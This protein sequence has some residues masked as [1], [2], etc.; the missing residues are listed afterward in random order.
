MYAPNDLQQDR[1]QIVFATQV[2]SGAWKFYKI[3]F[4]VKDEK[5]VEVQLF[6]ID[7]E[8]KLLQYTIDN[9]G[10]GTPNELSF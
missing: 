7:E 3:F 6:L 2:A 8:G 10:G 5:V 1:L 4:K 9:Y